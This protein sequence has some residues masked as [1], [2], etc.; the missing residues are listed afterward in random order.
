MLKKTTLRKDLIIVQQ[1]EKGERYYII[2]DKVTGRYFKITQNEYSIL[3]LLDGS[4]NLDEVY[5]Y[6]NKDLDIEFEEFQNFIEELYKLSLFEESNISLTDKILKESSIFYF[7]LKII[8]PDKFISILENSIKFL[9]NKTFFI[10]L[11]IIILSAI[12]ITIIKFDFISKEISTINSLFDILLLYFISSLLMS[13]HEIGH[14][15]LCK[16]FGG[17]V[18]EMGFMLLYFFPCFYTDISDIYIMEKKSQRIAVIIAG[19][20]LELTLWGIATIFYFFLPKEIFISRLLFI[21]MIASGIKSLLINFN[22]LIKMDGYYLLEEILGISNLQEK[23]RNEISK[24]GKKVLRFF[25][26]RIIINNNNMPIDKFSLI[27]GIISLSYI[28]ILISS[29]LYISIN[30][31]YKSFWRKNL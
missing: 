1:E 22:P 14:A 26:K 20:L 18:R 13:I 29:F 23:S 4:K 21:T 27:Y 19:S 24:I 3:L 8:N 25:H 15:L 17:E 31:I 5:S 9:I 2:K 6:I 16:H 12:V 30:Y 11:I 7:R 28:V 10:I